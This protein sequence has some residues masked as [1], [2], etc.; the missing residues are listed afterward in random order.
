M[1]WFG[2]LC[3]DLGGMN[4]DGAGSFWNS[5]PALAAQVAK[6]PPKRRD[7]TGRRRAADATHSAFWRT[8]APKV[9]KNTTYFEH[10]SKAQTFVPK[11][12]AKYVPHSGVS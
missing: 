12:G 3:G 9:M 1:R 6:A 8:C 4:P 2:A 10:S 11:E 7:G 5:W